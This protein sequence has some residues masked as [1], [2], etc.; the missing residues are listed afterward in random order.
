MDDGGSVNKDDYADYA[1]SLRC[2]VDGAADVAFTKHSTPLENLTP[3]QQDNF[4]LF[5]PGKAGGAH[6]AVLSR[7]ADA[8]RSSD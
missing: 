1:G 2:M 6:P 7:L 5:C 8:W 3:A 4:R